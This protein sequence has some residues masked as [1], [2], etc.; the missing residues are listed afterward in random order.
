MNT[1]TDRRINRRDVLTLIGI[2]GVAALTGRGSAQQGSSIN[3]RRTISSRSTKSPSS[4]LPTPE[5]DP[6]PKPSGRPEN[7]VVLD[8]AGFESAVSYT[9]DDGQPSQLDHYDELQRTGIKSTFYIS[10]N[11]D[12]SGY[13]EGWRQVAEDGHEIGNHTV[14]HPHSDLTGSSFGEPLESTAAEIKQCTEYIMETFNQRDVWTMA[15]PFGD[16]GWIEPAKQ[17]DVFLNRG[18]GGGTIA[19][20]DATNPF[21]LPCYTASDGDTAEI[22][23]DLVDSIH[24]DGEWLIYLFH[25]I[26]PTNDRWY[27]PV[28]ISEIIKNINYVKSVNNVWIDTITTIG[29]YWLGQKIFNSI[30]PTTVGNDKVWTWSLP[31]GFP[32]G[33]YLRV[34]TDGGTLRQ[35]GD[36]LEWDPHGYYEVSLDEGCLTLSPSSPGRETTNP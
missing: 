22:F 25:S 5:T 19:P 32:R 11:V 17:A 18:V 6:V 23:N 21:D 29:A 3:S 9:F 24:S 8:W 20:N 28:N 7:L 26:T 12:F 31:D 36:V 13:E 16:T 35:G 1:G 27:A 4:Q 10:S 33:Q 30:T 15:A 2:T 14:S 34:R